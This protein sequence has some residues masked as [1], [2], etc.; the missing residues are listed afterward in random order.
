MRNF[1]DVFLRGGDIPKPSDSGA[2]RRGREIGGDLAPSICP[3]RR[4]VDLEGVVGMRRLEHSACAEAEETDE[5]TEE[6]SESQ[7]SKFV[8][9]NSSSKSIE[10]ILPGESGSTAWVS[11]SVS[12]TEEDVGAVELARVFCGGLG[13][14]ELSGSG[15]EGG[16]DS[17]SRR[18]PLK[19]FITSRI[20]YRLRSG[21]VAENPDS[22]P[23]L[24]SKRNSLCAV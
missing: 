6:P 4:G 13:G 24:V 14:G 12:E 1:G 19:W 22:M 8:S 5:S 15:L 10:A 17:H 16:I 2:M 20:P 9:P 18:R 7:E 23:L 3:L 11:G 21:T